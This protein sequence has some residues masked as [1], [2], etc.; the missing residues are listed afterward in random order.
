MVHIRDYS[1]NYRRARITECFQKLTHRT[2]WKRW[3]E[4]ESL[5]VQQVLTCLTKMSK[6]CDMKIS[7]AF[8]FFIVRTRNNSWNHTHTVIP[9]HTTMMVS[10]DFGIHHDYTALAILLWIPSIYKKINNTTLVKCNNIVLL[11]QISCIL[12]RPVGMFLQQPTLH[13]KDNTIAMIRPQL[14][15]IKVILAL[16]AV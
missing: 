8:R 5:A 10:S 11:S 16:I 9:Q 6:K 7:I 14:F 3:K 4:P 15:L 12:E 13:Y 2:I 1:S